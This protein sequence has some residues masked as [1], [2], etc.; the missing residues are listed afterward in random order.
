M[1]STPEPMEQDGSGTAAMEAEAPT[2]SSGGAE[3]L[4]EGAGAGPSGTAGANEAPAGGGGKRATGKRTRGSS[5]RALDGLLLDEVEVLDEWPPG[6][7]QARTTRCA[8]MTQHWCAPCTTH[9]HVALASRRCTGW[10]ARAT[11]GHRA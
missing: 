2:N 11:F 6:A 10:L 3:V 5:K 8:C 4:A 7:K 9:M 1:A